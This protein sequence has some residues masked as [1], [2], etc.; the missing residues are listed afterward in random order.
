MLRLS[1]HMDNEA[2]AVESAVTKVL[3]AGYRTADILQGTGYTRVGTQ[4][5][6]RLVAA[7]L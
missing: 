2:E 7:H 3:D 6:S 5:M 1:F 4:E